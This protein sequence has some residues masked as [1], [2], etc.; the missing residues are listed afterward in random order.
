[1]PDASHPNGGSD[2]TRLIKQQGLGRAA[3]GLTRLFLTMSIN[4]VRWTRGAA[5]VQGCWD[6]VFREQKTSGLGD[7][8]ALAHVDYS[9]DGV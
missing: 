1:M 3:D 7:S 2:Q 5:K 6:S 8:L 9:R 4:K